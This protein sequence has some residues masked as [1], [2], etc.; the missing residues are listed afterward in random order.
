[1][2]L[3]GKQLEPAV[4]IRAPKFVSWGPGVNI[5]GTVNGDPAFLDDSRHM[6]TAFHPELTDS[7]WFH[8]LFLQRTVAVS[9][10]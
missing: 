10:S 4:F 6:I 2:E 9:K 8:R 3:T 1:M 7:S 5:A